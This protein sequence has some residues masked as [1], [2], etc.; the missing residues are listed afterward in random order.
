[1]KRALQTTATKNICWCQDQPHN[2]YKAL[3]VPGSHL[4]PGQVMS[5]STRQWVGTKSSTLLN[6]PSRP[7]LLERRNVSEITCRKQT[8]V[9]GRCVPSV[10]TKT[11][12]QIP[13]PPPLFFFYMLALWSSW[14]KTCLPD[15]RCSQSK[16]CIMPS[17]P[18]CVAHIPEFYNRLSC[19]WNMHIAGWVYYDCIFCHPFPHTAICVIFNH[20]Y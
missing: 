3:T 17:N 7:W 4:V 9:D 8:Q 13:S 2:G 1:M 5:L 6:I 15:I 18:I 12:G 16:P 20:C 11:F 19:I 10:K 14:S